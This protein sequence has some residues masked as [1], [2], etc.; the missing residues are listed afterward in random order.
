MFLQ[1]ERFVKILKSQKRQFQVFGP[2]PAALTKIKKKFRWQ[3]IVKGSR[4]HAK[5]M[6]EAVSESYDRFSKLRK[7]KGVNVTIDVDPLHML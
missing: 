4:E 7:I 2:A 5:A 6:R 3:I 1:A